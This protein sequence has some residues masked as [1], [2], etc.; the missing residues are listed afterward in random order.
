MGVLQQDINVSAYAGGIAAGKQWFQFTGYVQS[1]NQGNPD[2]AQI[3]VEYRDA[4]NSSVLARFDSGEIVNIGNWKVAQD[5]GVSPAGTSWIRVPL[6][7]KRNAGSSNDGYFDDITL[8]TYTDTSTGPTPGPQPCSDTTNIAAAANGGS[9]AGASSNYGGN[10]DQSK[11]ID[12]TAD[13]GWA[14]TRDKITNQ[15]VIVALPGN[16]TY[17]INKVRLN[18]TATGGDQLIN[19]LKDFQ[20]RV[21]VTDA[22]PGS[23]TT[24]FAGTS[25][26]ENKLFEYTFASVQAKY[27]M[28]FAVNNQGGDYVEIAEFEVYA[29]CK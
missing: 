12:G 15:Y 29:S 16:K 19:S 23:F 24:V 3:V 1:Y 27:V 14:G 7:A 21:S 26:G 28:I 6:I 8:S 13:F 4:N 18:P 9:I 22:N 17:T 10:W 5:K 11:L 25:T 2:S 20:I